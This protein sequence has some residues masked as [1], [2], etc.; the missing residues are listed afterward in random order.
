MVSEMLEEHLQK[1]S[2]ITL[3]RVPSQA[4]ELLGTEMV[5]PTEPESTNNQ[6]VDGQQEQYQEMPEVDV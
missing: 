4:M 1:V 6:I 5:N 3:N 2:K